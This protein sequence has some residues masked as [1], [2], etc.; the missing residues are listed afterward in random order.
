M[1]HQINHARFMRRCTVLKPN[2][3]ISVLTF[4]LL[5]SCLSLWSTALYAQLNMGISEGEDQVS[6]A[7]L[8]SA[9]WLQTGMSAGSITFQ[10]DE[11]SIKARIDALPILQVGGDLWGT[12]SYGVMFQSELGLGSKLDIP[13]LNDGQTLSYNHYHTVLGGRY[14]WHLS[15]NELAPAL[16]FGLGL[17]WQSENVPL[18]KPTYFVDRMTL[19]PALMLGFHMPFTEKLSMALGAAYS[20]HLIIREDPADSGEPV[21]ADALS[22]YGQFSFMLTSLL[23]LMIQGQYR[24]DH[25]DFEGFGTRASGVRY[26]QSE[27]SFWGASLGIKLAIL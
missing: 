18:Q 26:G 19:G 23:G 11:V 14:R 7:R 13:F 2:L 12:E 25:V 8:R 9:L 3:K 5:M 10:S 21:G 20:R 27:R 15:A 24:T 6:V 17:R 22:A 4:A 16:D 1:I